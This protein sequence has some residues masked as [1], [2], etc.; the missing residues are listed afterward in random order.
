M[1]VKDVMTGEPITVSKN[2]RVSRVLEVME[3]HD[4]SKLPA[5]ND[6]GLVGVVTD[7]GI[8][9]ELGAQKSAGIDPSSLY[10]STVMRRDVETAPPDRS[11]ETLVEAFGRAD[12]PSMLPV[13]FGDDLVGVVTK[14]DL[15][16]LVESETPVRDIMTEKLEAVEPDDRIVHARRIMLDE[17]V[18]RLPV[19][20]GGHVVGLL[21]ELDVAQG[22]ARFREEV[23][24]RHQSNRLEEFQV[25]DAMS[26]RVVTAEPGLAADEAAER[27]LEEDVGCL[28]V[29]AGG[30]KIRGLAT[31]SDLV[32]LL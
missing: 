2:E 21:A 30:D 19:L 1:D 28:P 15:L 4:I 6:D 3:K 27:M 24:S 22:L 13:V 11:V 7:G 23:P 12:G 10:A 17:D 14:A 16:P 5:T 31:R 9:D 25:E 32:R 8:A 26:R 29:V 20:E 18:E